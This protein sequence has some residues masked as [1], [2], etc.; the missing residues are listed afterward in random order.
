MLITA[1]LFSLL[2]LS[3]QTYEWAWATRAGGTIWD[4]G[5]DIVADNDGNTYV[6]GHFNGTATFGSITLTSDGNDE[7]VF[8]AKIDSDGD[9]VWAVRAGG[10]HADYGYGIAIDAVSNVYLIG[11]YRGTATFGATTLLSDEDHSEVFVAKIARNGSFVWAIRAGG[12]SDDSGRN[13][14]LD[15]LG[16]IYIYGTFAGTATFGFNTI[17]S[18]GWHNIFVAKLSPAGSFLWAVAGG[19][20]VQDYTYA[21]G[22]ALDDAANIYIS[23]TFSGTALFGTSTIISSGGGDIFAAKLDSG[24]NFLWAVKAGGV[25]WDY[26]NDIAV[27]NSSNAYLIGYFESTA[28]FGSTVYTSYG[29]NDIFVTKLDSLGNFLWTVRAGGPYINLGYSICVDDSANAYLTGGFYGTVDFG[30]NQVNSL[31]W[32]DIFVAKLDSGGNFLWAVQAGGADNNDVGYAIALDSCANVYLTGFFYE[33]VDFGSH[34]ITSSNESCD[35]F[36]AKFSSGIVATDDET[37]PGLEGLSRLYDAYPNPLHAG[38]TAAIKTYIAD[39][40][41]GILSFY[42]L[43]GQLIANHK[44]S[45]GTHEI[46]FNTKGLASGVYFFRLKTASGSSVKKLLLLK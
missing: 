7:D 6:T 21:H 38:N 46:S 37:A 11:Q 5:N 45:S 28:T 4:N 41:S 3:A 9:F 8:A 30:F 18:N 17:N 25:D 14:A 12:T 36:V 13:I 39:R 35:I 42:N 2:Y 34:S 24:G 20:I 26:G 23:G 22:L 32:A 10:T 27:D 16:N 31:G 15:G 1:L 29:E 44:L 43:R 19:A 40:E 33:S